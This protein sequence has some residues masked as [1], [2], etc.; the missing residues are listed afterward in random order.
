MKKPLLIMLLLLVA[1]VTVFAQA[2]VEMQNQATES[3]IYVDSLGREVEIPANITRVA[4]SGNVAQLAIYAVAPDKMV[5]WSSKISQS[6]MDVFL[7]EI[8]KLPV[9]GTFYGKKANLNKEALIA[10]DP[11][12]IIDVGEI[13]GSKEDMAKELD[14][15]SSNIGIPVIFVEGYLDNADKMFTMLGV[16]LSEEE[17]AKRLATFSR[18]ALD[19]G[20]DNRDKINTNLYYSS[21]SDGLQGVETGSFHGE[22]IEY[23]GVNNIVPKSFTKSNGNISLEQIYLWDPEVI[24]LGNEEAYQTVTTSSTWKELQAVKNGRVYLIPSTPYSFLDTPPATNRF[25]GI[26]WLGN[27]LNPEAYDVDIV[28][29]AQEYYDIFYHK[30]LTETEAKEILGL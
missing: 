28:A 6:A 12:V 9:F 20:K 3:R 26:Y 29:K 10:A 19:M 4:P 15:L 7:P 16:I 2:A 13:K 24:L 1:L 14:E 21:A 27:I 5:G 23:I 25:I 11:E 30:T 18:D 8:A 17:Q 22:V